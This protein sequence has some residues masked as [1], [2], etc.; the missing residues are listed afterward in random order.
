MRAALQAGAQALGLALDEQ[1][2]ARLLDFM[3]LLQ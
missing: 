2:A 3:A 1:Q